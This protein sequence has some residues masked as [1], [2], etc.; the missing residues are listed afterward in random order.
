MDLYQT[1]PC[2]S[3]KK[4]KFCCK[5][6][7]S[8]LDRIKKMVDGNQRQ[9]AVD[10]IDRLLTQKKEKSCLYAMKMTL[11]L[12]A[13]EIEAA[14]PV[15]EA[16]LQYAPDSAIALAGAAV[17]AATAQ[18]I[19]DDEVGDFE[20][21]S[22]QSAMYRTAVDR[23]QQSLDAC[24]EILPVQVF[25]AIGLVAERLMQEGMILAAKEH[26]V[27][28]ASLANKEDN[29]AATELSRFYKSPEV[30][31]M[32]KQP[33]M[34][35]T[36]PADAPW[37]NGYL[38]IL[39]LCQ[40]GQ[41]RRSL[42]LLDKLNKS[43][44]DQPVLVH[45]GS[46]LHARLG[47]NSQAVESLRKFADLDA[48]DDDS[49]IAAEALAQSLDPDGYR[50]QC[51]VVILSI[52][53]ED[54]EAAM[55]S[56][57]SDRRL[58]SIPTN[59]A[60]VR[61]DGEPPPRGVF[62]LLDREL[63]ASDPAVPVEKLP[64]R[65]GNLFVYGKETDR[66]ARVEL[67][68]NRD[69][70]FDDALKLLSELLGEETL[71]RAEEEVIGQIPLSVSN[72][73][74]VLHFPPAMRP[75]DRQRLSREHTQRLLLERWPIV[76]RDVLDGKSAQEVSADPKY[77][78]RISAAVL[79]LEAADQN[80]L[81]AAD[82]DALRQQLGLP[83]T[84]EFTPKS[85]RIGHLP[86]TNLV[87]I[88]A[89]KLT[90]GDLVVAFRRATLVSATEAV[91]RFGD[92]ILRRDSLRGRIDK[93]EVHG[94]L[95]TC[96]RAVEETIGHLVAAQQA[97]RN[98]G[99]SPAFFMIHEL[100]AQFLNGDAERGKELLGQIQNKYIREPGVGE[101][102]FSLLESYGLIHSDGSSTSAS[103]PP[104]LSDQP[105]EVAAANEPTSE[106]IWVP[107]ESTSS[108]SENESESKLWV[109]GMD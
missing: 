23:L 4:I 96:Q 60:E 11:L 82:F 106:G 53:I 73:R 108:A 33:L 109:P 88:A 52:P 91:R 58:S 62:W 98:Q 36:P 24:G 86:L 8:E 41:W 1:C 55:E 22:T 92:E 12:H 84:S 2:G 59:P 95:A 57:F 38:T 42:E 35:R 45:C 94:I 89:A 3:G 87:R 85:E 76:Q 77:Q 81:E 100:E 32:I 27:F 90:D 66:V 48:V 25:Q 5:S 19:D 74:S 93:A 17:I 63:P 34:L 61:S 97:A 78:R 20:S 29:R 44:P 15:V 46:V 105:E 51:D 103:A 71:S 26:L 68:A 107:G 69:D 70:H 75:V 79:N 6:L 64:I 30:S 54:A 40:R 18:D 67:A 80:V 56:L 21:L 10:L 101:L 9:A 31:L 43:Y 102:L 47:E 7:A 13:G 83:V 72:L 14:E 16:F 65:L 50:T 49:A 28:Q 104:G 37:K 39:R 99:Q